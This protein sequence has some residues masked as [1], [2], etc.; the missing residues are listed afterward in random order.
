ML[1]FNVIVIIHTKIKHDVVLVVIWCS[2]FKSLHRKVKQARKE[3]RPIS[4]SQ[5]FLGSL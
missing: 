3:F 2:Q 1:T 5:I 4:A